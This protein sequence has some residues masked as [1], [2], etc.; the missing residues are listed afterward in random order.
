MKD[1]VLNIIET[2]QPTLKADGAELRLVDIARDGAVTLSIK[3]LCGAC[4]AEL[5]THRL[6]IER[7]FKCVLP[8]TLV[9]FSK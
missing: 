6:R 8:E 3:G 7:A 1:S 9:H 4:H 5:W 2:L